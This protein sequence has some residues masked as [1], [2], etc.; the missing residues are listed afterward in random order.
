MLA[1]SRSAKRRIDW[2]SS[3][4]IATPVGAVVGVVGLVACALAW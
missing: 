2:K 1:W 4:K 3:A